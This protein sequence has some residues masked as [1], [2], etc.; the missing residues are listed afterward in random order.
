M[1]IYQSEAN[2]DENILFG[3][4]KHLRDP[5]IRRGSL[6]GLY[7]NREFNIPLWSMI[8]KALKFALSVSEIAF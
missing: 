6:R 7:G 4:I 5:I 1:L 8:Y 3:E 2:L